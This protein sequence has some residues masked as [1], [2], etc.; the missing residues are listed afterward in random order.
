[1]PES[2]GEASGERLSQRPP[3]PGHGPDLDGRSKTSAS[4]ASIREHVS[5]TNPAAN[6]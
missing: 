1:M 4:A 6:P 5:A 2:A 3:N